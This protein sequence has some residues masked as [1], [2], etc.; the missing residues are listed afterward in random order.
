[1]A[2][3]VLLHYI[4]TGKTLT[5]ELFPASGGAIVN[6]LVG[7][8]M[9]EGT[10]GQY[11]AAVD[12]P[13]SGPHVARVKEAGNLKWLGFVDLV[14]GGTCIIDDL[15]A[16]IQ[17]GS[18]VYVPARVVEDPRQ[19]GRRL[20][21]YLEEAGYTASFRLF[22]ADGVTPYDATGQTIELHVARADG[23]LEKYACTISDTNLAS[24]TLPGSGHFCEEATT[25]A[26][27][28]AWRVDAGRKVI[29]SGPLWVL[30]VPYLAS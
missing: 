29:G 17:A 8:G 19:D 21:F 16:A 24:F 7:D 13:L 14:E 10:A 20:T 27:W 3:T 11:S 26:S 28:A 23:S 9:T 4:Q 18:V 22:Q 2:C 1:M 25:E 15:L 6:G 12:E 5:V 30:E